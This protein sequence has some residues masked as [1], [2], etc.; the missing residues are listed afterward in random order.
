MPLLEHWNWQKKINIWTDSKYAF[1]VLHAH[2]AIWKER[3]LL[4][5][6]GKQIKHAEEIL[7]LL[8]AVKQPEKV[9]IVHC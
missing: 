3:G 9:A 8:E 4:T 6:Q 7:K 5:A 1:G 2:G